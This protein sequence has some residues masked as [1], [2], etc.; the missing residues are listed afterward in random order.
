M[1]CEK[2]HYSCTVVTEDIISSA[3]QPVEH[4]RPCNSYFVYGQKQGYT[5]QSKKTSEMKYTVC[6]ESPNVQ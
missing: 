3:L 1:G 5:V 6:V 2:Q 4:G